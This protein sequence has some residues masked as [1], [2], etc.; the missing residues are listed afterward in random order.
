MKGGKVGKVSAAAAALL[1]IGVIMAVMMTSAY[2]YDQ[3]YMA[4]AAYFVPEDIRVA[5]YCNEETVSIWVNTRVA[6]GAGAVKFYYDPNCM[7]VTGYVGNDSNWNSINKAN[8]Q[9][10][11]VKIG[12]A[13]IYPEGV[14]PGLV[15]IGDITVHC[16]DTGGCCG[17]LIYWDT[18]PTVSYL[19]DL[20]GNKI[21]VNWKNATFLCGT[22]MVVTKKVLD[23]STGEWVDALGPLPSEWKGKDVIFNITVTAKCL[24][25]EN[26]KVSDVMDESLKYNNSASLTP[27]SYDEHSV[28]WTISSLPAGTSQSIT[29]NATIVDYGT[30]VDTATVSATVSNLGVLVS[31]E[32]S[33]SVTTMPPARII[34]NK[35]VWD[36]DAGAWVEGIDD[37]KIGETYRFRCVITNG[38]SP[39][40]DLT[41][42]TVWDILSPSMEYAD[43][44]VLTTPAGTTWNIE[45]PTNI[46][47]LPDGSTM[48]NWT[49]DDYLP[50]PL[51]LLVGQ[52][53]VIEFNA[54]VVNYGN[55]TN[56]QFAKGWCD[57]VNAWIV[58]NDTA[59]INT[60]PPDITVSDITINYDASSVKNKAVGPLPPGTKTQ[61][62]NLSATISELNGVDVAFPFNVKFEVN[63]AELNCSPVRV[64]A[65]ALKGGDSITVYC[66]CSFYPIAGETYNISVVADSDDEIIE[67]N[68]TNNRGWRNVTAIWNGY[69]G[70]GWQDGRNI[71]TSQC[72]EGTINLTYSTGDSYYQSGATVWTTYEAN[73]TA[74]DFNIPPEGTN[75]VKARLYVYYCWD[76]T[77]D[78][79]GD[80]DP[81]NASD[82]Y[83]VNLTFNGY[84][85]MPI[86]HYTDRKGFGWWD[87]PFGMIV[88]DV[89]NEFVATGNNK[90]VLTY[91]WP[92]GA[93]K[94][95]SIT[96]MLLAVVYN[97]TNEPE[98]I[99]WINDGFD[100]IY[101]KTSYGISSEEATTY[102]EFEG[103][104]PIPLYKVV[105]AKL[106]TVA[107]HASDGDDK[108]RLY[109][110][111]HLWKGIWNKYPPCPPGKPASPELGINETDVRAY[112][113]E[114]DNI[115][116]FQS[117]IPA[118]GTKG[119]FMAASN[120]FLILEKGKAEIAVEVPTE[121]IGQGEQFIVNVTVNPRGIPIYGVEYEISFDPTVLHAEWQNEGD[122][123]KQ[124]GAS[125]NV[126]V[127]NIDNTA[128][129]LTFA[130]T[131]VGT[132]TGVTTPGILARIGF[133]ALKQGAS[134][135]LTFTKVKMSDPDANSVPAESVNGTVYVCENLPPVAVGWSEF[136]YNNVGSKYLSK[137]YFNG[138]A[139][140][141]QD[142]DGCITN[143][144][145]AFGDGNYGTGM[146]TEHI[147]DS[148]KWN[149]STNSYEPFT[150]ILTVEDDGTPILDN[151]T[152]FPVNVFIA[153]DANGDGVVDIFDAV[154][155]GLEWD[156]TANFDGTYYWYDNERGDRADLNND[157]TV[158]IFDAVIVGAN[159]EHTAW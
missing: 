103:C 49:I 40:M 70:D 45:P 95:L 63:G 141:D 50:S 91:T 114:T 43:D 120:A 57:A 37:A 36:P 24:D 15:H 106:V 133:T 44:A 82:G 53:L 62:N 154:I 75:I 52:S 153:G 101:A 142:A 55:D 67:L 84:P 86:A 116:A 117:H 42:I 61:C 119:D 28:N 1:A 123:L 78:V 135:T 32:D 111:G 122:F 79:G 125:T 147:Y 150:V 130:V 145:W 3:T 149:G 48:V 58:G 92:S 25:L 18:D 16:N 152:S 157:K 51:T 8:L 29:F 110:N 127:N 129:K 34:V 137:A 139:S 93:Y 73:W 99:I 26:V 118:G 90:A 5:G 108:N 11:W 85:K 107:P 39:G 30:G 2:D 98:R 35:T 23:P 94:D 126:Y 19:Q 6:L 136:R 104:E 112:L 66:D 109:F 140:Y 31:A 7:N 56:T 144:R 121:C 69:K 87:Y 4:N 41:N 21:S 27:D 155:V 54:T 88:Y 22:P 60:P 156:K 76:K 148:W 134:T 12:F 46:K 47:T 33:A 71:S 65:G 74:S 131:R 68:E 146:T 83:Y 97:N 10:G 113:K 77:E 17:T 38:G 80:G 132:Q 105:S 159:W 100:M 59:Y 64:P 9:Y 96:G 124:G 81:T 14:G 72:H 151:S 143:Y 128:G 115:A 158:D 89:T 13:N 102:A 20:G 138:S